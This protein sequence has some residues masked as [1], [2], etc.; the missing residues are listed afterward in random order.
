[1]IPT[2]GAAMAMLAAALVRSAFGFGEALIAVPLLSLVVPVKVA[3]PVAV[4]ASVLIAAVIVAEDWRH[5]HFR[6]AGR[7]I[8]STLFG[9][10][11]GLLLLSSTDE[12]VIKGVLGVV[13]A[14][15]AAYSLL[16]RGRWELRDDRFAWLFGWLAG[17]FGGAY[18]INGPPL[19][20][21]GSLRGWTP[22]KFRATLQGYF[23][24]ASLAGMF[25]YWLAGLWTHAV[26]R[27]FLC[28]LPS[29][30]VGFL[31]G[32][33]ISRRL[34]ARRFS[35]YLHAAL[36]LIGLALVAQAFARVRL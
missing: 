1:L 34:D 26:D 21:Y 19:V 36:V 32:R 2:L 27:L 4:L 9:V 25:G 22:V 29:I 17:V 8:L 14:A 6:S 20:V 16:R 7:L 10:P 12:T 30:A 3:A 23:L 15:F 24:P 18:G 28:S 35:R 31:A 33:L 11:F 13:I 5:I